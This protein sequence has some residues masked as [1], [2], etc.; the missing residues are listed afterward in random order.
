M[1]KN[2][3]GNRAP[4]FSIVHVALLILCAVMLTTHLT[5][6]L[7]ARY[8]SS[9][10]GSDS[11]RVAKFGDITITETGDDKTTEGK[12]YIIP[13]VNIKKNPLLSF[14]GSES[15]TYVFVEITLGSDWESTDNMS[16]HNNAGVSWT[17]G[18]DWQYL[19]DTANPYVYYYI[20]GTTEGVIKPNTVIT[21][22]PIIQGSTITVSSTITATD[23]KGEY[24]DEL[25]ITFRATAVQS[26]GFENVN[27]AWAS[28]SAKGG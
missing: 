17:V 8:V 12:Y 10:E 14:A 25:G 23:L 4:S 19:P 15:A 13:G 27:A 21:N 26:I 6:G 2:N 16:F 9:A 3:S 24:F 20:T 22:C 28:I 5:G 7:N 18:S 11:A 1:R